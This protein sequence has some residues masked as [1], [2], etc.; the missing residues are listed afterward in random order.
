MGNAEVD[1]I[2]EV[3]FADQHVGRFDVA[4]HQSRHVCRVQRRSDLLDDPHRPGAVQRPIIEQ[5]LQVA[6][7][8][9]PHRH[10]QPPVDLANVMNRHD[11]RIVEARS[12]AG[13]AAEPLSNNRSWANCGRSVF[14]ATTRSIPVS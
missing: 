11:V 3:V 2:G 12:G 14:S 10:V 6:A 13:F 7:V 1:Q 5:G 4:V 8:D 9:Q